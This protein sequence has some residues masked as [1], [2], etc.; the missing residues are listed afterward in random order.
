M[1]LCKCEA[2]TINHTPLSGDCSN[3]SMLA[4]A[5]DAADNYYC[6]SCLFD[7]ISKECSEHFGQK[8]CHTEHH[9]LA[10][11]ANKCPYINNKLEDFF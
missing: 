4:W 1:R 9:C 2:E 7:S 3:D 8:R 10:R 11:T 6:E 5:I